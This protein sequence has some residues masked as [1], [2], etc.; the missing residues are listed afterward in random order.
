[1]V[2]ARSIGSSVVVDSHA[3][4]VL[5]GLGSA[6]WCA[7]SANTSL[8]VSAIDTSGTTLWSTPV[9]Q[10]PSL[11]PCNLSTGL[12]VDPTMALHPTLTAI[13]ASGA[14]V[15]RNASSAPVRS[16]VDL[17]RA[18]AVPPTLRCPPLLQGSKS[19]GAWIAAVNTS[20]GAPIFTVT[21]T[22]AAPP[23]PTSYGSGC[24]ASVQLAY[25]LAIDPATGV[26]GWLKP[27]FVLE[28]RDPQSGA[29]LSQVGI[30]VWQ[31]AC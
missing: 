27:N 29:S 7:T 21:S 1:M 8:I 14:C 15:L 31:A 26:L 2:S 6:G 13:Y 28:A 18:V 5:S 20:T 30:A 19:W 10:N 16:C 9:A 22:D 24:S 3:T 17:A 23:S 25:T 12:W 4:Y 11:L